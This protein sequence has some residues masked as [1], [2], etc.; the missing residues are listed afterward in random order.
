MKEYSGLA[1]TL[2]EGVVCNI[3][4]CYED[5][6]L[7]GNCYRQVG[8]VYGSNPSDVLR[9]FIESNSLTSSVRLEETVYDSNGG[10]SLYDI[11]TDFEFVDGVLKNVETDT[12]YCW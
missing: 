1:F 2:P 9:E 6:T 5:D 7:E 10:G 8:V 11:F 12:C 4:K 3:F